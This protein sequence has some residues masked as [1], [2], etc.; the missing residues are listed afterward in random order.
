MTS[1]LN[2]EEENLKDKRRIRASRAESMVSDL[3][4]ARSEVSGIPSIATGYAHSSLEAALASVRGIR[5]Y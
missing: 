5:K 2:D 4:D 1:D 3:D